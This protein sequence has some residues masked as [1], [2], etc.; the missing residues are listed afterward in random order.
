MSGSNL[1]NFDEMDDEDLT[2]D[3]YNNPSLKLPIDNSF[4]SFDDIEPDVENNSSSQ[5][6]SDDPL[7]EFPQE[8]PFGTKNRNPLNEDTFEMPTDNSL[9][10][11]FETFE[12]ISL[13][14]LRIQ[15]SS[16]TIVKEIKELLVGTKEFLNKEK[17]DSTIILNDYERIHQK[18]ILTIKESEDFLIKNSSLPKEMALLKEQLENSLN[19][20]MKE[21][22]NEK[23]KYSN[24]LTQTSL[25]VEKAVSNL[26]KNINLKPII[27]KV[28]KDI[29]QAVH[30][31]TIN[32]VQQN[33]ENFNEV[34]SQLEIFSNV[35]I[36]DKNKNGVLKEFESIVCTFDNKFS[37]L[38]KGINFFGYFGSFLFGTL[39]ATIFTYFIIFSSF[40]EEKNNNLIKQTEN[41]H[42]F[43][44]DKIY[45][46][47]S[48]NRA[49]LDFTKR[50][51][52]DNSNF[53][54]NYFEDNGKPYFY[55]PQNAKSFLKDGKIYIKLN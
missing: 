25:D 52:I 42:Q 1:N 27:E 53:G 54:F 30:D 4:P 33:L 49:Y 45:N 8:T 35:L 11:A 24:M 9:K 50:Y 16:D 5:N 10:K 44:K 26:T 36:G 29:G 51:S 2:E 55:Y 23:E 46:L 17:R 3:D 28:N 32:K 37:N 39:F 12:E 34:C 13:V 47:E 40:E 7:K 43:Y 6:L 31:S 18:I 22:S 19:H 15:A 48:G 21:L 20:Y 14:N 41:I 38:K